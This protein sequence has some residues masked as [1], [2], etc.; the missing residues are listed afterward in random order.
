MACLFLKE[1]NVALTV[2]YKL[3]QKLDSEQV[4]LRE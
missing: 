3:L 2:K 4:F 1:T